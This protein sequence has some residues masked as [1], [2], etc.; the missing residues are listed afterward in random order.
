MMPAGFVHF[1]F[2][3]QLAML[4]GLTVRTSVGEGLVN[5]DVPA[6]AGE[7]RIVITGRL[8]QSSEAYSMKLTVVVTVTPGRVTRIRLPY[9]GLIPG[10]R[11]KD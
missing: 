11:T 1:E 5:A 10:L 7:D 3:A 9:L 8:R 4:A 6:Q 2:P